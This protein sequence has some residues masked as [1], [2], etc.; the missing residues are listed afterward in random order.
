MHGEVKQGLKRSDELGKKVAGT[1]GR[2][3]W[4]APEMGWV[5]VNSDAGC[6]EG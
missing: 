4:Q 1:S 5:K 6:K 3:V 2:V